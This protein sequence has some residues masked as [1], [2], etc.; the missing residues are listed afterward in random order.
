[1]LDVNHNQNSFAILLRKATLIGRCDK[2]HGFIVLEVFQFLSS[3]Q[4][5]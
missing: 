2:R 1:L 4:A 3:L 5:Y